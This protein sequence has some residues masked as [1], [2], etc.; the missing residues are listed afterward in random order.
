[1]LNVKGLKMS[2]NTQNNA[3]VEEFSLDDVEVKSNKIEKFKVEK[4]YRYRVGLPL[5]NDNGKVIIKKVDF[6]TLEKDEGTPEAKFYSWRA[7]GDPELDRLARE[8]GASLKTRYVTLFVVYRTNKAGQPLNPLTWDILP[9]VMDGDKVAALKEVNAEWDLATIDL[10]IT[11]K[12]AQYQYHTYTPLKTA[13]WKLPA[14]DPSLEKLGLSVPITA[15]VTAAA[16]AAAVDMV[17]AVAYERSADWIKQALGLTS[18]PEA[19]VGQPANIDE[20]FNDL[21][22]S[23]I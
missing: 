14:G 7:S 12:N 11:T 18:T 22:V 2:T 9:V 1:M 15:E 10:S 5:I 23:D 16:K 21:E 17:D 13:I 6:F 20:A 3:A 8:R 4:D 19:A